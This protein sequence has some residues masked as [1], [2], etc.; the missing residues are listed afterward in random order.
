MIIDVASF[1]WPQYTWLAIA[2]FG[3]V[4]SGYRH[5]KLVKSHIGDTV[6]GLLISLTLLVSGGFF[7]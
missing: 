5:G 6:L 7:G 1:G 4:C 2:M 3:L